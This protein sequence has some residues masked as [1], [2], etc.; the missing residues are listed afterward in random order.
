MNNI[1]EAFLEGFR[2]WRGR[3]SLLIGR[4]PSELNWV[5]MQTPLS[6]KLGNFPI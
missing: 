6:S 2:K 1:F 4:N 3:D 5:Y